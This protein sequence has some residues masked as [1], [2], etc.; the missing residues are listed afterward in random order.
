ML[1]QQ[2]TRGFL[3]VHGWHGSGQNHWQ[4]WLANRLAA[5]GEYVRYPVLPDFD[6]PR[7]DE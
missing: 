5:A 3:I 4:T 2:K 1:T 6:T 7:L